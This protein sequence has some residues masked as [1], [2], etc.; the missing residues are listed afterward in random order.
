M[1]GRA[2]AQHECTVSLGDGSKLHITVAATSQRRHLE[3]A[4]GYKQSPRMATNTVS[5][6]RD[7]KGEQIAV[8]VLKIKDRKD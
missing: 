7:G 6:D 5:T 8:A 2:S 1:I 4:R 3:V